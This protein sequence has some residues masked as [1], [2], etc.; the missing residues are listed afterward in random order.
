MNKYIFGLNITKYVK[1]H[2]SYINGFLNSNNK[3]EK[4][5]LLYHEKRMLFLQH[6]R[7]IHLVVTFMTLVAALLFTILIY[8]SD[9]MFELTF[10]FVGIILYILFACYIKH[11]FFLE[12]HLQY[13]YVLYDK[14]MELVE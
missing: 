2:E 11:Y 5:N 10:A 7:L 1:D 3:V 14:L 8:V 4:R 6:E 9:G 13:W 12:N